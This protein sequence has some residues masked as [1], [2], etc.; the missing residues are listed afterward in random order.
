MVIILAAATLCASCGRFGTFGHFQRPELRESRCTAPCSKPKN[1]AKD[2]R[3]TNAARF[4]GGGS[5]GHC[6]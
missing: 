5:R 2:A 1:D 3:Q 6:A 4:L